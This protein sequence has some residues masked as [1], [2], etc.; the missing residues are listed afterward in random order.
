MLFR[1]EAL[2]QFGL[3]SADVENTDT[4]LNVDYLLKGLA[5]Y[6]LTYLPLQA[7]PLSNPTFLSGI[8]NISRPNFVLSFLLR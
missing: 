1:G 7:P 5:W 6:F 4:S 8:L 3:L 2:R